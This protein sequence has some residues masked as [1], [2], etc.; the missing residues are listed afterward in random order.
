MF[1]YFELWWNNWCRKCISVTVCV[2]TCHYT[3]VFTNKR[4]YDTLHASLL[5]TLVF[6]RCCIVFQYKSLLWWISR[7]GTSQRSNDRF[8]T[9]KFSVNQ[10][11]KLLLYWWLDYWMKKM[12]D[13]RYLSLPKTLDKLIDRFRGSITIVASKFA[14]CIS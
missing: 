3:C 7:K 6:T 8:N 13:M 11:G 9:T 14:Y 12:K 4:W 2:D 10:R 5:V 1:F